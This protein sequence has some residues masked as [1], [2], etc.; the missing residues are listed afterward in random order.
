MSTLGERVRLVRKQEKL[1]QESF[2][3]KIGCTRGTVGKIETDMV[4]VNDARIKLI[5]ETFGVSRKWLE[6]GVG[7]MR[8][9][10]SVDDQQMEKNVRIFQSLPP[11]YRKVIL[12]TMEAMLEVQRENEQGGPEE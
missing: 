10:E 5:C 12:A 8:T 3:E 9:V 1:S 11:S 4:A 2:G 6:Q 7:E